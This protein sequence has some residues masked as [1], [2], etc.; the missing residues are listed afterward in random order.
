MYQASSIA[1]SALLWSALSEWVTTETRAVC[2]AGRSAAARIQAAVAAPTPATTTE[3]DEGKDAAGSSNNSSSACHQHRG[4]IPA[5][6]QARRAGAVV[7]AIETEARRHARHGRGRTKK[8]NS[9]KEAGSKGSRGDGGN[10]GGS[11]SE[12]PTLTGALRHSGVSTMVNMHLS[13]AERALRTASSTTATGGSAGGSDSGRRG[14][15]RAG[16]GDNSAGS[17]TKWVWSDTAAKARQGARVPGGWVEEEALATMAAAAVPLVATTKEDNTNDDVS[18]RAAAT[19]AAAAPAAEDTIEATRGRL[20]AAE[21]YR[22][23]KEVEDLAAA[24][25]EPVPVGGAGCRRAVAALI[26]TLDAGSASAAASLS[27]AQ[28]KVVSLVLL[29]AV[30]LGAGAVGQG[31]DGAAG[32]AGDG[33]SSCGEAGVVGSEE[34][35]GG[36]EACVRLCGPE[37]SL[38]A[39]EF[40]ILLEVLL[41]ARQQ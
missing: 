16:G 10:G 20:E 11:C 9:D 3:N 1:P 7:E 21:R 23:E 30:G 19:M 31:A 34:A 2:R 39:S 13:Q 29:T 32:G 5:D 4:S 35:A 25:A 33:V 37:M 28:W 41:D 14:L 22:A 18:A 36:A 17:R 26:D 24:A 8:E 27:I 38:S 12:G 15:H 6:F 40:R